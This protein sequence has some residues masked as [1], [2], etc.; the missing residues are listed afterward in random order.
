M[1]PIR[2]ID[3]L[4][5]INSFDS[6]RVL[7]VWGWKDDNTD[8]VERLNE[9][10]IMTYYKEHD[11]QRAIYYFSE[12]FEYGNLYSMINGFR[13]LWGEGLFHEAVQWLKKVVHSKSMNPKCIWNLAMLYWYGNEIKCNPLNA[14][15]SNAQRLLIDLVSHYICW[16]KHYQGIVQRAYIWLIRNEVYRQG[17]REVKP[18][19]N[20]FRENMNSTQE[21]VSVGKNFYNEMTEFH[22]FPW[23]TGIT[24]GVE[25]DKAVKRSLNALYLKQGYSYELS[26]GHPRGLHTIR[27]NEVKTLNE[28][29]RGNNSKMSAWQAYLIYNSYRILP[30]EDSDSY[31]ACRPIFSH[32]DLSLW[33]FPSVMKST[34]QLEQVIQML[35]NLPLDTNLIE[36]KVESNEHDD[37]Q[38][39]VSCTWWNDWKGLFREKAIISIAAD[40]CN[41]EIQIISTEVLCPNNCPLW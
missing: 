27:G 15:H 25:A 14:S 11:A 22:E 19:E 1:E 2:D 9:W 35:K 10:G 30:L 6:D 8:K 12:A 40:T 37:T 5:N 34:N 33:G 21:Y 32:S 23:I 18:Y 28:V 7:S 3:L 38:F 39:T 17:D 24:V 20:W 29:L 26:I 36:P 31:E 41:P 4:E 16:D 13:V